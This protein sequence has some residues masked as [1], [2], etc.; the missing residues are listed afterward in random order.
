M[1]F[2]I[3]T[4]VLLFDK[5]I[6]ASFTYDKLN[7]SIGGKEHTLG[8]YDAEVSWADRA[9]QT[10]DFSVEVQWVRSQLTKQPNTLE[11]T[12]TKPSNSFTIKTDYE[13]RVTTIPGLN[14]KLNKPLSI[15]FCR[16]S[17]G[18]T[19]GFY[20]AKNAQTGKEEI[21][22]FP[23]FDMKAIASV[24]GEEP[25][26]IQRPQDEQYNWEVPTESSNNDD[27]DQTT[28]AQDG[29]LWRKL[30][31]KIGGVH[32]IAV[33]LKWENGKIC[34]L[35]NASVNLADFSFEVMGLQARAVP[36]TLFTALPTFGLGGLE[37]DFSTASMTL[38]ASL[39]KT[40]IPV[41]SK[42]N[43][44]AP[45][46]DI[47]Q[48]TG[49]ALLE[50]KS[51]DL[52]IYGMGAYAQLNG[53]S[54]LF[55]YFGL[56]KSLGGPAFFYV[57]GLAAGIGYNRKL[58]LSFD[59]IEKFPL[60]QL[61]FGYK[62]LSKEGLLD[63]SQEMAPY[64]PPALG[65]TFIMAGVRFD[66]YKI[67]QSFALFVFRVTGKFRVD[68]YGVS[69]LTLG[70]PKGPN[71]VFIEI[72][73]K[74]SFSPAL[75]LVSIDGA[76]TNHSFILN[77]D[78]HLTGGFAFYAWWKS[79]DQ[80][81]KAGD[82][83]LTVGGYHPRFK[84]PSYYPKV[85][86]VSLDWKVSDNF[87][88]KGQTFFALVPHAIMAG[89]DVSAL[90]KSD[91]LRASFDAGMHFLI[92]WAPFHYDI[93]FY[94]HLDLYFHLHVHIKWIG[95]INKTIHL[96]AGIDLGIQ[97]PPFSATGSAYLHIDL[98]I[99]T[100]KPK[101]H[102]QI[103][104]PKAKPPRLSWED[105]QQQ[106]LQGGSN[107]SG[108]AN[109]VTDQN[110]V[111]FKVTKGLIEQLD[112]T[113][114]SLGA[115][116][117]VYPYVLKLTPKAVEFA[118]ETV[119][120]LTKIIFEGNTIPDTSSQSDTFDFHI[121][122]VGANITHSELTI[123]LLNKDGQVETGI[124]QLASNPNESAQ[125]L[126]EKY[127]DN[128][129]AMP[130]ALWGAKSKDVNAPS[131]VN[132]LGKVNLVLKKLPSPAPSIPIPISALKC[133]CGKTLPPKLPAKTTFDYSSLAAFIDGGNLPTL[134]PSIYQE[135]VDTVRTDL[136]QYPF[137]PS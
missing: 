30:D 60:I 117:F 95:T 41:P 24:P 6:D 112:K 23:K 100:I 120:P 2:K 90:Y 93:D 135:I 71:Y 39:L 81:V 132:A 62:D 11:N 56:N 70:K 131:L 111:I 35:L 103:G 63:L 22:Q 33:G 1:S 7:A 64:I 130:T 16:V 13:L 51:M 38:G 134:N 137:Y 48:Y 128:I 55:A 77:K 106:L 29:V 59:Q 52:T 121:G 97:G 36:K 110:R 45:P 83:V 116:C 68:L 40:S 107:S 88:V 133:E 72:K 96:A 49:A 9:T 32:F 79:V 119:V 101:I 129:K 10:H 102:I 43:S 94:A 89:M 124:F 25:I 20:I 19:E 42:T 61:A 80:Q 27:G 114:A 69:R 3:K 122:P 84:V 50:L 98:G 113:P 31:K 17:I 92:E 87:E 85:P 99:I 74:G 5:Q 26:I 28:V 108:Y 53:R 44:E 37:L 14:I 21:L 18:G 15:K 8:K 78:V 12:P 105:F 67:V 54:S 46:K 4:T 123:R 118:I 82:F 76:I 91:N 47:T 125:N 73:L 115:G 126:T 65:N 104:D 75:G 57:K 34:A 86:R 136:V 66:T 58:Q 109:A 127:Q